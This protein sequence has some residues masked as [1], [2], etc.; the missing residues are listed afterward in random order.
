MLTIPPLSP[1][2]LLPFIHIDGHFFSCTVSDTPQLLRNPGF[3]SS[4]PFHL[5]H[6]A[7]SSSRRL[8]DCDTLVDLSPNFFFFFHSGRRGVASLVDR[9]CI[10]ID[11]SIINNIDE[12]FSCH[13]EELGVSSASDRIAGLGT[14]LRDPLQA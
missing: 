4:S 3:L 6:I 5:L 2:P 1:H 12:S 7:L 13:L 8:A 9:T 10:M 11:S 14:G